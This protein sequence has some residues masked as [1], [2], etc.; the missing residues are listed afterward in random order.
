MPCARLPRGLLGSR[1]AGN[2]RRRRQQASQIKRRNG[3]PRT[4]PADRA[5]R[6]PQGRQL[7]ERQAGV[8]AVLGGADRPTCGKMTPSACRNCAR[9]TNPTL[10]QNFEIVLVTDLR[11][12]SWNA[13]LRRIRRSLQRPSCFRH[14]ALR[15]AAVGKAHARSQPEAAP[16][17]A[18][19][20]AQFGALVLWA[21]ACRTRSAS[22]EMRSSNSRSRSASSVGIGF[23]RMCDGVTTCVAASGSRMRLTL[24][25]IYY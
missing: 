3:P 10:W 16:S 8:G 5:V 25:S 24:G 7:F 21:G 6:V 22:S 18:N 17:P 1:R 12:K 23:S 20:R 2:S 4:A 14:S 9:V 11:S 13:G 19:V 15:P